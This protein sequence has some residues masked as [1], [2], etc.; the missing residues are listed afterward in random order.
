MNILE[1]YSLILEKIEEQPIF[2]VN[3]VRKWLNSG[4]TEAGRCIAHLLEM[5]QIELCED[6]SGDAKYIQKEDSHQSHRNS[7]P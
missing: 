3:D 5:D 2:D 7:I 4:D 6:E 1:K